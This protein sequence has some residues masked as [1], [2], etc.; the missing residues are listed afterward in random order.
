[1]FSN[2]STFKKS[3]AKLAN[4][5]L[6]RL[7]QINRPLEKVEQILKKPGYIV[8]GGM[9][10][11][12]NKS[13]NKKVRKTHN[14]T[15]K[16]THSVKKKFIK[17]ILKEWSI[18]TNGCFIKKDTTTKYNG[19]YYLSP[20]KKNSY[21]THVHLC[22]NYYNKND[23]NN[24]KNDIEYLFKKYNNIHSKSVCININDDPKIIVK[25]MIREFKDFL[26]E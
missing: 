11:F 19:D 17:N 8:E 18:Q 4:Q 26:K 7:S 14:K 13:Y 1:M 23:K 2:Q 5:P 25:K 9:K 12:K 15:K 22:L 6:E 16:I 21:D 10:T 20:Y 24:T 3:G